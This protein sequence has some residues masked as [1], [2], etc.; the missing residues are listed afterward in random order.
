MI[1]VW[2][3]IELHICTVH[4]YTPSIHTRIRH[5]NHVCIYCVYKP[6]PQCSRGTSRGVCRQL[7]TSSGWPQRTV[8]WRT[9]AH[10]AWRNCTA[11]L[12][13]CTITLNTRHVSYTVLVNLHNT[14]NTHIYHTQSLYEPAQYIE[15]THI[16]HSFSELHTESLWTC[17][18]HTSYI[19]SFSE[20]HTESLWTC[21]TH[22]I[23][24]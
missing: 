16:I 7:K 15:H 11:S 20:L 14:L 4:A 8:S 9:S 10:S 3:S 21:T 1:W 23:H 17:T 13:T 12:W 5:S 24:K 22:V 18:I 2:A 19:H 6:P